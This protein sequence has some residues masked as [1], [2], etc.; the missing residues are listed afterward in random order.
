MELLLF[1]IVFPLVAAAVLLAVKDDRARDAIVWAT[2]AIVAVASIALAVR[3]FGQGWTGF[4]FSSVAVDTI[5]IAVGALIAIV[6]MVYGVKHRNIA[7]I[8]LAAIQ[9]VSDLVFEFVFAHQMEVLFKIAGNFV[10]PVVNLLGD[11][12]SG[13]DMLRADKLRGL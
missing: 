8:V 11:R 6:V 13:Q 7:A 3:Y 10:N 12:P 4:A 2:A 1:L 9:L 5:A